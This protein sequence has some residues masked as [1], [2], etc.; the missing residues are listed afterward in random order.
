MQQNFAQLLPVLEVVGADVGLPFRSNR[1]MVKCNNGHA[2][3]DRPC[4]GTVQC[5]RVCHGDGQPVQGAFTFIEPLLNDVLQH[6]ELQ[7]PRRILALRADPP[8]L[9]DD[10]SSEARRPVPAPLPHGPKEGIVEAPGHDPEAVGVVGGIL[11]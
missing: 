9:G 11:H 8:A 5:R 6:L 4:N 3:A 1:I 2:R 10:A 7:L